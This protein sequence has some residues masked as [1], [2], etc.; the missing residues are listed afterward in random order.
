MIFIAIIKKL[1][2]ILLPLMIFYFFRKSP[3]KNLPKK[4]SLSNFDKS[5]IVEGEI[6][7]DQK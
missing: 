4:T 2:I 3:R 6:L 5:N 1:I 7:E